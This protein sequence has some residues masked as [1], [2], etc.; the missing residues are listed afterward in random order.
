MASKN[1]V[2]KSYQGTGYYGTHVPT[3]I[4]RNVLENPAGTPST[5]RT[6]RRSRRADESLLNHDMISDLRAAHGQ[7]LASRRGYRGG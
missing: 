6:R 5:P 4:L 3:V 2:F 7:R 1:K